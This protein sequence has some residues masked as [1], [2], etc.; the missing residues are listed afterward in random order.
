MKAML[1]RVPDIPAEG[2]EVEFLLPL[3]S[4]NGRLKEA[5]ERLPEGSIPQ[6]YYI[7]TE[8]PQVQL[9]VSSD[10]CD[11]YLKG[12]IEAKFQSLCSRCVEETLQDLEVPVE[13]LLKPYVESLSDEEK[14]E[15]Q[16][17]GYYQGEEINCAEIVEEFLVLALPYSVLCRSECR[18]LCPQCGQNLNEGTCSCKQDSV[19]DERLAILKKLKLGEFP[20]E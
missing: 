17:F 2:L 18:G 20:S 11:V 12:R 8:A 13:L 14:A 3:Q 6:P 10:L 1:I 7:F 9:Q 15:D 19:G 4:L 16:A 5:T